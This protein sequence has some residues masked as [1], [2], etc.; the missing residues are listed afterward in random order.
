MSDAVTPWLHILAITVWVGPQF[1]LFIAAIPAVRTIEDR[2]TRARVMRVIVT[3]WMAW[4]AMLVIVLTGISTSSGRGD[5]HSAGRALTI[6]DGRIFA[7]KMVFVGRLWPRPST[8]LVGPRQLALN[9]QMDADPEEAACCAALVVIS[10]VALL[11][12]VFAI[13]MGAAGEL[14][15]L[16]QPL[17]APRKITY[18]TRCKFLLRAA[19]M[20]QELL[21]TFE[22]EL[23]EVAVGQHR[24]HLRGAS[25][26]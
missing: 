8:F 6:C 13:F 12:S 26:R 5:I 11:A 14:F 4:A 9:E 16:V 2:Q 20:A 22:S 3:R 1:F 7:E 23:S 21:T 18:C 10:A 25:R 15:I 19:W 17:S 24:R